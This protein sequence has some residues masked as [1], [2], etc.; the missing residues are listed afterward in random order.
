MNEAETRTEVLKKS[1]ERGESSGC[2]FALEAIE[3][4]GCW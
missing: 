2:H 4:V 1:G 3:A